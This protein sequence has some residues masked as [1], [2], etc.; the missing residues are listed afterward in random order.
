ML[1]SRKFVALSENKVIDLCYD[2]RRYPAIV[3]SVDREAGSFSVLPLDEKGVLAVL[4][5][6]LPEEITVKVPDNP[7]EAHPMWNEI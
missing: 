5:R 6:R 7:E 4:D 2:N 1:L 3:V